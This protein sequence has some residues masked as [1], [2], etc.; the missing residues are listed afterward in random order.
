MDIPRAL[1][2]I[3]LQLARS[4]QHPSGSPNHG[5]Q[6]VAPL[7]AE[8]HID[9]ETWKTHRDQCRVRRFWQGR[10]TRSDTWSIGQAVPS[11]PAG[12]STTIPI[13]TM[14]TSPAI[15]SERTSLHPANMFLSPMNAANCH[16]PSDVGP[17]GIAGERPCTASATTTTSTRIS[18]SGHATLKVRTVGKQRQRDDPKVR[19]VALSNHLSET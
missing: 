7:D 6:F 14:T 17:T 12:C 5:Y 18:F 10:T 9:P 13:G 15:A 4:K 8:G 16:V 11:M 3:R 2:S 1:K 19:E